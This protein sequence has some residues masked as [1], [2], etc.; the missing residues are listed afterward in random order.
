MQQKGI[1]L[2]PGWEVAHF[3]P[4][5]QSIGIKEIY[6]KPANFRGATL[7]K[8]ITLQTS[9]SHLIH[10]LKKKEKGKW[11]E[12]SLVFLCFLVQSTINPVDG[13]YQPSL[14]TPVDDS[15]MPT[16]TTLP[17]GWSPLFYSASFLRC[18]CKEGTT[19][20]PVGLANYWWCHFVTGLGLGLFFP[21]NRQ[22]GPN[23]F[24]CFERCLK[25]GIAKWIH[26]SVTAN[27]LLEND[28]VHSGYF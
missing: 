14:A 2:V 19:T 20:P 17:T 6:R 4:P 1:D 7:A 11:I 27:R 3:I 16:Q 5:F 24:D 13:I 22:S 28:C 26:C 9:P 15:A 8:V 25:C 12:N 10:F 21:T 23:L 18:S